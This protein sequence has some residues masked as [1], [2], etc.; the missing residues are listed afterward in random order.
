MLWTA[1]NGVQQIGYLS[2]TLHRLVESQ[3]QIATLGYVDTL[4]EQAL[5]E[6]MLENTKP[7]YKEDLTAYHYLLSTPFRYPPLKWGSRFGGVHEP[8]LFYGGSSVAVTLAESA[9]YRFV[10]WHSMT[11]TPI[12]NQIKSE[13]SLFSASYQSQHCISLQQAPFDHYTQ[14]ISSPTQYTQSQQLGSAMRAGGVEAFEYLSARDPQKGICVGLFTARAFRHKN[15]NNM[16][17]WL[18]ETTANEV[19]FKQLGSNTI[20]SFKLAAFQVDAKLPIPA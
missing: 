14:E 2:G 3:E 17:Q 9:Y 19:L 6:E 8:S 4:D 10:F 15:P 12:K 13:H 7:V 5:L 1:C 20:T 16:S 11:G 18:C